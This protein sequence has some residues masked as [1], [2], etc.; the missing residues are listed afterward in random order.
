MNIQRI[1]RILGYIKE[2]NVTPF[3]IQF[4]RKIIWLLHHKDFGKRNAVKVMGEDWDY[5]I[6]LDACR[7]DMF[8][9]VVDEKANYVISGGSTTQE[10]QIWNFGGKYKDV[11]YIAGN[12][13]FASAHLKKNFGFNPFYRVEEVWDY[14]WDSS[15]KTVPPEEVTIAA[16]NTLKSFPEKKMIIHYNQ[17]HHPFL[18]DKE[19]IKRDDGIWHTLEGGLW[20]GRKETVWDLAKRG[21]V[22]IERVKEAYKGN[23]KIVMEEVKK[24]TEE[25]HGR[26][27]LT[28]DHGNLVGE[29]G[30]YGHYGN[31]RTEQLVKVPWVILKDEKKEIFRGYRELVKRGIDEKEIVKE[32]IKKLRVVGKI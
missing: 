8:K 16:L 30:L 32:K 19:L 10:W 3:Y 26:V 14:G 18:S 29:Y 20:G 12:P 13:H 24:I 22:S 28:S 7:Y 4:L 21:E 17:P 6:I 27:I 9:E 23:L 31:L 25:L 1:K 15:V 2:G 5:L 11:V